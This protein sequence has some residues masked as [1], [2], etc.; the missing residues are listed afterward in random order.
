MIQVCSLQSEQADYNIKTKLIICQTSLCVYVLYVHTSILHYW[1]LL[2]S[3]G[4]IEVNFLEEFNFMSLTRYH[5]VFFKLSIFYKNNIKI[6]KYLHILIFFIKIFMGFI[7]CC[8]KVLLITILYKFC[9]NCINAR[10]WR[11]NLKIIVLFYPN[12][13]I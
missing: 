1:L 6:R 13:H 9:N 11:Q 3:Y 12:S 10:A 7:R 8:V 2:Y 5:K 4:H